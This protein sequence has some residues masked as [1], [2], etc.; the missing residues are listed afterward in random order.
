MDTI[1]FLFFEFFDD[2][3]N[4]ACALLQTLA[5]HTR[6][7]G[8]FTLVCSVTVDRHVMVELT[9]LIPN[10]MAI[11]ESRVVTPIAVPKLRLEIKCGVK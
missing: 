5:R 1:N 11:L 6:L 10:N 4:D 2:C 8:T 7:G 3:Q 9:W